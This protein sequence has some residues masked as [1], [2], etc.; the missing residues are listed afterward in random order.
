MSAEQKV[1]YVTGA[2]QGLGLAIVKKLLEN[3]MQVVATSRNKNSLIEKI[4]NPSENF[5]P[6][7]ANLADDGSVKNSIEQTLSQFGKIDV[8]VN[9]AGY[10]QTGYVEELSAE[11]IRKNIDINIIGVTNVIRNTLAHLRKSEGY[12]FNISSIGGYEGAAG[13]SL[14]SLTKFA[15]DGFSEALA[16]EMQPFNVKVTCIKPGFFRTNFL[17][18]TSMVLPSNESDVYK[19]QRDAKMEFLVNRNGTQAGSPEK[20]AEMLIKISQ[21]P[22]PPINLFAG[23]DAYE[24]AETK[25]KFIQEEMSAFKELATATDWDN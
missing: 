17:S 16:K 15:V 8:I 7:S 18:E 12:I 20:F 6:L 4:G 22:N 25:I 11:D 9:N 14:Y 10:L 23:A 3:G 1:W 2:S 5:L 21:L 19:E 13:S 24:V